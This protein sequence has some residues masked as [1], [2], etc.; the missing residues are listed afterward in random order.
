[1]SKEFK[2]VYFTGG[3]YTM[4]YQIGAAS[5]F[6][7]NFD[8]NTINWYGCSAGALAIVMMFISSPNETFQMYLDIADSMKNLIKKDPF[9]LNNYNL[10]DRHFD[11]FKIIQERYPDAYKK[12]DGKIKIGVT[13]PNGFTWINKFS[14]NRELFNVLLNSFHVPGLC[15]YNARINGLRC[16]DGGFGMVHKEHLPKNTFIVCPRQDINAQLNGFMPDINT[17]IPPTRLQIDN[18]YKKGRRDM[19]NYIKYGKKTQPIL[20]ELPNELSIPQ[21]IWHIIREIQFEDKSFDL[22]TFC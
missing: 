8:I 1:M 9:N 6:T 17:V 5:C 19:R 10:T 14:S 4:I 20:F 13:T 21:F 15:K 18:F 11:V 3:S 2:D 12:I 7:K 22:K 16:I